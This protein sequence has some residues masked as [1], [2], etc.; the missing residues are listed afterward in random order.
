MKKICYPIMA[1]FLCLALLCSCASE[2]ADGGNSGVEIFGESS[3]KTSKKKKDLSDCTVL[4]DSK[5][6]EEDGFSY[7][8]WKDSGDTTMTLTGDGCFICEWSNINN[9]LFRTG[10]KFDCTKTYQEIGNIELEYEV[11]YNPDGNSYLCLYG[12][13]REPL[14]EYYV[15]E[16]WGNWRP[17]GGEPVGNIEVDGATYDVYRTLRV[18]QPSID[19]NTTFEQYWSVRR[20]KSTEGKINAAAHFMNWEALGMKMGKLYE[21]ALTVEGYQSRGS[22]EVLKNTLK[23]GGDLPEIELPEQ[24]EPEQPDE[25]GY[26]FISA[27]DSDTDGWSARGGANISQTDGTL[28]ISDRSQSWHGAERGLASTTYIP[29]EKFSFSVRAMQD[30]QE[31]AD[32]KLTLQ[33]NSPSGTGYDCIA[34]LN[35]AKGEW[36]TLENP[37]YEIPKDSWGL[38]LYVETSEGTADFY[39]DDASAGID[40]EPSPE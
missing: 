28:K 37:S 15:V 1:V 30:S 17:P 5:I 11:D 13:T 39:I 22:A 20:E 36:V 12:W 14:V 29:G 3:E 6:G 2:S 18:N 33:Y 4:T 7:E 10:R 9:A 24:P 25:N 34:E 32:F 40:R 23:V 38:V 31:S 19:G 26:Y 27:F 35:G 21:A 8:L 16:S